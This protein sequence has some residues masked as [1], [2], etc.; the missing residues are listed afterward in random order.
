[1]NTTSSWA[2]FKTWTQSH[3][4][5]VIAGSA[6]AVTLF[7]L[8]KRHQATLA[9]AQHP[10]APAVSGAP[11]DPGG[12]GQA[13]ADPSS[14]QGYG[15][16]TGGNY[17]TDATASLLGQLAAS[18]TNGFSQLGTQLANIKPGSSSSTTGGT[19]TVGVPVTPPG[20][21]ATPA[22]PTSDISRFGW[23]NLS[24]FQA[25]NGGNGWDPPTAMNPANGAITHDLTPDAY[26]AIHSGKGDTLASIAKAFGL[27]VAQID[28]LNP[29]EVVGS[30]TDLSNYSNLGDGEYI[31]VR[32][33]TVPGTDAAGLSAQ[34]ESFI[35]SEGLNPTAKL[36]AAGI[37]SSPAATPP[38]RAVTTPAGMK[39]P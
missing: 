11:A 13:Y 27:T 34:G 22:P 5:Q 17:P 12:S 7:A 31:R 14:Y 35:N 21:F 36:A 9:A 19:S 10:T 20:A 24:D 15:G 39:K 32:A 3:R 6:G 2:R 16:D 38:A 33:S 28:A 25:A 4:T 8:Y 18:I 29:A 26:G 37:Q 30:N 1:M 23:S